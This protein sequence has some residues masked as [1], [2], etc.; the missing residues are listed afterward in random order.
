MCLCFNAGPQ[1]GCG[2]YLTA[3]NNTFASPDS[4]SNGMYDKN[5][6]C[7]WIIIGP[8]N[9]VIHLTFNTFALEAAS[10]GQR[11]LYDYVKVSLFCFSN[12]V[13]SSQTLI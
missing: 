6:N 7:V 13:Y 4:D 5:L 12:R 10:T 3:L 1:Q 9:K 2:G 11:C 8:V